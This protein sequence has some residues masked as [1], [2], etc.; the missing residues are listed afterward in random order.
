MSDFRD[1]I[2]NLTPKRLALLALEL[3]DQV[4]AMRARAHEPVAA[5]GFACR[6]PGASDIESFWELLR[7][8]RD[9]IGEV[10]KNRWDI[11]AYFDPDPDRP[12]HMA[13]RAGGFLADVAGFD[14]G[15]FGI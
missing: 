5:V 6:F 11:D 7:D 1:R 8:G 4:E 12:G 10:P 13:V 15:F 3:H 2:N 14:A 9:A